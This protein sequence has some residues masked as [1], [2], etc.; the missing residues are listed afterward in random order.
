VPQCSS[1]VELSFNRCLGA[2]AEQRR[3]P[4][5]ADTPRPTEYAHDLGEPN[6]DPSTKV[7]AI[8]VDANKKM[9]DLR[10]S[11]GDPATRRPQMP[12][13]R[14]NEQVQVEALLT[15]AKRRNPNQWSPHSK[16]HSVADG[17]FVG[18]CF[19]RATRQPWN[20]W[21]ARS[22]PNEICCS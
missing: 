2:S 16:T 14:T 21:D 10:Y 4:R 5:V 18:L 6:P 13:I 1:F 22:A 7:K 3:R 19:R 20:P 9:T 12:W 8:L 11:G 15:P 17:A